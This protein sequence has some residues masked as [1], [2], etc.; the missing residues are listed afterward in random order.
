M[1]K[2]VSVIAGKVIL[3]IILF[4]FLP[5]SC[6]TYEQMGETAAE[7]HR[8]HERNCRIQQRH[9]AAGIHHEGLMP[10]RCPVYPLKS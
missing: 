10:C 2:R 8:R 3:A 4:V 1:M 5:C 6:R 7:G 9:S